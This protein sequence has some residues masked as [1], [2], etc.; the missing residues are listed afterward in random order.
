M[1][2]QEND[3]SFTAIIPAPFLLI[4][5]IMKV[6]VE[7]SLYPLHEQYESSVLAFIEKLRRHPEVVVETN[8]LSTQIFGEYDFVMKEL[9]PVHIQEVFKKEKAVVVLKIGQGHL[10]YE[11]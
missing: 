9:L 5:S 11:E 7:I 2:E 10:R 3:S 1:E 6:T 8:G 4:I